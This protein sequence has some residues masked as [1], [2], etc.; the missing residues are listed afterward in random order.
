LEFEHFPDQAAVIR[1]HSSWDA[2]K[3]RRLAPGAAFSSHAWT[4]SPS[5]ALLENAGPNP[6]DN[7]RLIRVGKAP[8][9]IGGAF[10]IGV[11]EPCQRAALRRTKMAT[12]REIT[13]SFVTDSHGEGV[14]AAIDAISR[15]TDH[16]TVTSKL[17]SRQPERPTIKRRRAGVPS[18]QAG[19][20]ER[21]TNE[22]QLVYSAD[23]RAAHNRNIDVE[24]SLKK[25]GLTHEQL[26]S[27]TWPRGSPQHRLK[28]AA[29]HMA[30][31]GTGTADR[32]GKNNGIPTGTTRS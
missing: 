30:R 27:R 4:R 31:A 22:P 26:V 32:T 5:A 29:A 7:R 14:F 28:R 3:E 21:Q 12:K 10:S 6:P 8:A 18:K 1:L 23:P 20:G 19:A 24:A 17:L 13:I 2:E 25:L 9:E 15:I 16:L 11:V